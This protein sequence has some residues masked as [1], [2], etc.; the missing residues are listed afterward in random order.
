VFIDLTYFYF[1]ANPRAVF[2][3]SCISHTVLTK[4]DWQSI[5][6]GDISLPQAL[7]CWELQ[8]YWSVSNHLTPNGHQHHHRH[9][10]RP[11]QGTE[12]GENEQQN[13]PA[14]SVQHALRHGHKRYKAA[15]VESK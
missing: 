11:Q 5:R 13:L 10:H 7:R 6:I 1:W 12:D 9:H 4:R 2:S 14:H 3:P 8:P 15:N